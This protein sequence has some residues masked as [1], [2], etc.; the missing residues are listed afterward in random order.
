MPTSR[1]KY[2]LEYRSNFR[3]ALIYA[4]TIVIIMFHLFPKFDKTESDYP[5]AININI[6]VEN[7][8]A[9]R[10]SRYVPPPPRPAVPIPTDDELIPA[11][12]T[13]E[14]TD[15][16]ITPMTSPNS[17]SGYGVAKI[18]SPRLI[19]EVFPEYPEQD[20]KKGI[21]GVVKLHVQVDA[22]GRVGDVVVLGNTTGSDRCARA[23]VQAAR[24]TRYIPARKGTEPVASWTVRYI[25]FE[26]D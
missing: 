19:D 14:E 7:I 11:D 26:L 12:E 18:T 21:T 4:L 1:H 24:K 13:I 2:N 23:A 15:L 10:Q 17:Q 5:D 20:Y 8:P 9:T 22:K 16:R 3:K 6:Q 25:R